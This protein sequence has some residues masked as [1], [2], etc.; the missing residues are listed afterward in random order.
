[1]LLIDADLRH[2]SVAALL[3]FD[4]EEI[5]Y[6]ITAKRYKITYLE[7][8]KISFLHILTG[9]DERMSLNSHEYKRIFDEVKDDYDIVLVDTPPCGLVSDTILQLRSPTAQFMLFIRIPSVPPRY[10]AASIILW[11]PML[12]Y[13]AAF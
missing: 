1:M 9:E 5:D 7:K 2:P 12:R 6:D 4:P 8:Y 10:A 3:G 11:H 13:S